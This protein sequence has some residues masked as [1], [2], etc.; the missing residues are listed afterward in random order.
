MRWWLPCSKP[1]PHHEPESPFDLEAPML[2]RDIMTTD[3]VC[4]TPDTPLTE[5]ATLMNDRNIGVLLVVER[6]GSRRL[7][8][9]ITD[10]DIV[11]R[12]VAE[13]HGSTDCRV[14]EAMT[15]Q[16]AACAPDADVADVMSVMG[17][18]Q[19]RRVPI[20][21]PSGVPVGIVSQADIVRDTDDA[22]AAEWTV[23]QISMPHTISQR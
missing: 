21:D 11:T 3:L 1:T 2:A 6:E 20:V 17:R 19:V 4:V 8:G 9:V 10:R 18:E 15:A 12:H 22:R 5:A 14:D 13:G 23:E 16:V 7:V